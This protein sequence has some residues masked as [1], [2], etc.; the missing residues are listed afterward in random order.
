MPAIKTHGLSRTPTYACW[1]SM[2]NRCNRKDNA[3][4]EYYGGRGITY[5]KRWESFENFFADMGLRPDDKT[6]DRKN[7]D[8]G[9]SK[10]NCRWAT[11]KEQVRNR[12]DNSYV[13]FKGEKKLLCELAEDHGL[14]NSLVRGRLYRSGWT[15]EQ[16]LEIEDQPRKPKLYEYKGKLK[17]A[18]QLAKEHNIT[19]HTF[20]Y[21]IE[22][23]WSLEETLEIDESQRSKSK[24]HEYKG[25]LKKGAQWAD[26]YNIGRKI[27]YKR[28]DRGWA[29]EQALEIVEPPKIVKTT[30][31]LFEYNGQTKTVKELADE[32]GIKRTTLDYRLSKGLSVKQAIGV[33]Q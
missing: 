21:R 15:L 11:P 12:R 20:Y 28:I 17:T 25:E 3:S 19:R 29:L 13:I 30:P 22:S 32:H 31:R 14:P 5:C 4:Y 18:V 16:A 9:Y 26:E 27:F 23:G 10:E 2:M 33:S 24:L 7:N 6:L 8:K 1:R